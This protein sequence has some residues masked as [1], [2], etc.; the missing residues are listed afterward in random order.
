MYIKKYNY[1][2]GIWALYIQIGGN[3]YGGGLAGIVFVNNWHV[4]YNFTIA[5]KLVR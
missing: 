1:G 5:R 3:K 2:V 4:K